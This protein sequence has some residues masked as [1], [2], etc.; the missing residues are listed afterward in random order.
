VLEFLN[1][2]GRFLSHAA[3]FTPC[4]N[5][6]L[7]YPQLASAAFTQNFDYLFQCLNPNYFSSP[8]Q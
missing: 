2:Q 3:F 4:S 1:N 5:P 7:C 6:N 8:T